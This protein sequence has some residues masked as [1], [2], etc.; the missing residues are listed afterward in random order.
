MSLE[1][2][3]LGKKLINPFILASAPPTKDYEG[4]IN[5]FKAGWAGAV[6]KS[7][8]EH[9]LV[10]KSPR[11][12]H[13][14]YYGKNLA[15]QNYEMGSI[16]GAECWVK[17][18]NNIKNSYPDRLLLV[19]LFG[20]PDISEWSRLSKKFKDTKADGYELNFSCP[21]ADHD[22][23]GSVIGQNPELCMDLTA[24]VREEVNYDKSIIVKLPYLS[25]PNEGYTSKK[26]ISA[27]A[28]GVAAINTIAGL[29]ELDLNTGAPKLSTAG[30]TTF[31][32]FSGELIRPFARASIAN[33]AKSIDF[34][35]NHVSAMGGVSRNNDALIEYLL[36]G[37][38][39]IQVCTD[40]MN[41][42]YSIIDGLKSKLE[43][44]LKY[45]SL[46]LDRLRGNSLAYV[47]DWSLLDNVKRVSSVTSDCKACGACI[48]YCDYSAISKKDK[49]ISIDV[50]KCDGCGSCAS[51]CNN[52]GL[53]LISKKL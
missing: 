40:V 44:Y 15:T 9:V 35:T 36:L 2:I 12:G 10:D 7:V 38:T 53:E 37:A 20:G 6:T 28:D 41:N 42:G 16:Y 22:G 51:A 13:T 18:V 32:G 5:G 46:S 45:R 14:K 4:I 23:K 27:G 3:F 31:G 17:T 30:L 52:N 47:V 34:R 49:E 24:A 48:T 8:T 21:H 1:T 33:I 26:C 39:T 50:D 11:I 29:S 43:T 25:H 19:S